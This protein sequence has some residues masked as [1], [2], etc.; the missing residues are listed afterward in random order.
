MVHSFLRGSKF[1]QWLART[2]CPPA[3]ARCKTVLDTFDRGGSDTVL[4]DFKTTRRVSREL[5]E[6][7]GFRELPTLE[8]VRR[9][10]VGYRADSDAT[11]DIGNS[12][13]MVQN[14][15]GS[16]PSP[17]RIAHIYLRDNTI[18]L[19]VHRLIPLNNPQLLR[20]QD[21]FGAFPAT[22]YSATFEDTLVE[23]T[24]TQV[25]SH[26]AWWDISENIS[27]VL[28]LCKVRPRLSS[29]TICSISKYYVNRTEFAL[30]FVSLVQPPSRMI[31]RQ[32]CIAAC[33]F[34][35]FAAAGPEVR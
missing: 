5:R 7:T 4:E 13:V 15:D 14:G 30:T 16:P 17:V 21:C 34:Y 24:L 35:S 20:V 18:R 22:L 10:G 29:T 31:R 8:Y 19:A 27:L 33:K 1:R 2:D 32:H 11:N 12:L 6:L 9:D 3:L 25:I 23:T 26:Y 28:D